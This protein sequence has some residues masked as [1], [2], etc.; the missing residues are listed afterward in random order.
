MPDYR[1]ETDRLIL[2]CL[3]EDDAPHFV[4]LAGDYEV[5]KMTLNIPHP[6]SN[7]DAIQFIK[8]SIEAWEKGERYAFAIVQKETD[9]F[10]GV[11]GI[12]PEMRHSRAEVGYWIGVPYWGQGYMT[13][14]LQ[15]V[16]QFGFETLN[17]NRIQ[18]SHRTDNPASG[19]VMEKAGM[20]Y[21]GTLRQMMIRDGEFT[22]ISYRSILREDYNQAIERDNL[23]KP[24]TL[25]GDTLFMRPIEEGDIPTI[26]KLANNATIAN[27]TFV[28][29][30]Y[31]KGNAIEFV[32]TARNGWKNGTEY[33]F[34]VCSKETDQ[35]MGAMGLHLQERHNLAEVG[36]WLGEPYWGKGYA[37][38]ALRLI[39]QFGFEQVGLNRI[40]AGHFTH[41]P[42]SGRV[43]VKVGLQYEGTRRQ[44]LRH[45]KGYRDE[46]RY[47]I[48][49]EDYHEQNS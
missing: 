10:M 29:H 11:I 28:P 4:E 22:D 8:G 40:Q 38:Q 2:R 36:Y 30:P 44:A 35:F 7:D 33:I 31:S 12:H 26:A 47:A 49:R 23:L 42:A 5:S 17:L 45:T 13:E 1:F 18:A 46:S 48:L 3:Q 9:S 21:E 27:N 24:Y 6:Y 32:N 34:A 41:N 15:R 14:A 25:E 16:I 37:T 43:M 20:Q 39:V 19:R